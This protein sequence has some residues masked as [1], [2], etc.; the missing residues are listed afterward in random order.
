M[1]YI[2]LLPIFL[3]LMAYLNAKWTILMIFL[4]IL[5]DCVWLCF[6]LFTGL[7]S[8]ERFMNWDQIVQLPLMKV[9]ISSYIWLWLWVQ[10]EKYKWKLSYVFPLQF[11][12]LIFFFVFVSFWFYI[13][14]SA[15]ARRVLKLRKRFTY[16]VIY[17]DVQLWNTADKSSISILTS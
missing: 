15:S 5:C 4:W 14:R 3:H 2:Y 12:L 17:Y 8:R 9:I 10:H 16:L 7:L 1:Y 13:C 11:L 6:F